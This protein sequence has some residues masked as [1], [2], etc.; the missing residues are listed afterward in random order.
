MTVE[1]KVCTRV[2]REERVRL[3]GGGRVPRGRSVKQRTAGTNYGFKR[4]AF[5]FRCLF[6]CFRAGRIVS[7]RPDGRERGVWQRQSPGTGLCRTSGGFVV[8][9]D[10]SSSFIR[11]FLPRPLTRSP[12]STLLFVRVR[13]ACR[14]DR[15]KSQTNL[16]VDPGRSNDNLTWLPSAISRLTSSLVKA[17]SLNNNVIY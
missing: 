7:G 14:N 2:L 11:D 13:A 9:L 12:F 6:L 17:A 4:P 5:V 3:H 10:G 16:T 8:L 1:R 15:Q